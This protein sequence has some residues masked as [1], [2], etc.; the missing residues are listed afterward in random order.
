MNLAREF[1]ILNLIRSTIQGRKI[2]HLPVR[3]AR[4]YHLSL[5]RLF[6]RTYITLISQLMNGTDYMLFPCQARTN[7]ITPR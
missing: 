7:P 6:P 1:E 3:A 4:P 5:A 2:N